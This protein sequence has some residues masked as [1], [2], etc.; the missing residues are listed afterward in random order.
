MAK[1]RRLIGLKIAEQK[2]A[3]RKEMLA[4]L[5]ALTPE[6]RAEWSSQ[7]LAHLTGSELWQQ[8]RQV[9]IFHPLR[10]EPDVTPLLDRQDC[11]LLLPRVTE[12]GLDLHRF[13]GPD[14]LV[15]SPF[16]M[17][18]PDPDKAPI[19]GVGEV[20]LV[21]VPGLAFDPES[22]IRLGRGGGFYD[23]LLADASFRATTIGIG[24]GFQMRDGL[25]AEPHD[26]PVDHLLSEEGM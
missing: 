19:V 17:L 1:Q 4:Q 22:N 9:L 2:A 14:S 18:E 15:R 16:G 8:A 10:S 11:E 5:K 26:R 24:F 21:I 12:N 13:S 20:D 25:P 3:I 6:R 7:T 23:R